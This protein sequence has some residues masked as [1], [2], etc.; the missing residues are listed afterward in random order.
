MNVK[1][2]NGRKFP[3]IAVEEEAIPVKVAL[4]SELNVE[5]ELYAHYFLKETGRKPLTLGHVVV[6]LV[7]TY[8]TD[9]QDFQKW[10]KDHHEGQGL[11][12]S[13]FAAAATNRAVAKD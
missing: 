5:L 7:E 13:P 9:N 10:K 11:H 4:R 2:A 3:A 8:L 6:G 1:R 12:G